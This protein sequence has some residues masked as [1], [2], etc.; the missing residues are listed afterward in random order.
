VATTAIVA[1]DTTMPVDRL[2]VG[3]VTTA[4]T[5]AE[6]ICTLIETVPPGT[7]AT[8]AIVPG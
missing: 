4:T 7:K 3:M 1:G 2:G 5:V 8:T 6:V